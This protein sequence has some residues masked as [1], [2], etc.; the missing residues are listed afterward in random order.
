MK[1]FMCGHKRFEI[2]TS[3][4]GDI[5]IFDIVKGHASYT[6]SHTDIDPITEFTGHINYIEGDEDI[7]V[8]FKVIAD[9]RQR[10]GHENK[11][12][13]DIS[14]INPNDFA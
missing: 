9:I 5:W 13:I 1:L 14:N 3:K 7:D 4:L 11:K 6:Y 12:D 2:N 8:A 10:V